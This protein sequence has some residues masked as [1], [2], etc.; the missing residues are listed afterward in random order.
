MDG[1]LKRSALSV[2]RLFRWPIDVSP[3]RCTADAPDVCACETDVYCHG[4]FDGDISTHLLVYEIFCKQVLH[5]LGL[6]TVIEM[7]GY[8]TNRHDNDLGGRARIM[9]KCFNLV[10]AW[11]NYFFLARRL[12]TET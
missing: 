12:V 5:I 4:T 2:L 11:I 6:L 3:G 1:K 8:G 7:S 10:R 9:T